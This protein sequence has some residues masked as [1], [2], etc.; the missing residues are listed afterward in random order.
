M[1]LKK[2]AERTFIFF[3]IVAF[4]N[5]ESQDQVSCD[6]TVNNRM[7]GI[8]KE[9]VGSALIAGVQNFFQKI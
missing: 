8:R 4:K 3:I 7:E 9:P 2:T 6:Q 5:A 1:V